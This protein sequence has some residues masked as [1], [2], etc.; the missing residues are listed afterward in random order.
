M[1]F[2][3]VESKLGVLIIAG[4]LGGMVGVVLAVGGDVGAVALGG[5]A[6]LVG[7]VLF[8]ARTF[9]GRG[10]SSSPRPWWRMTSSCTASALLAIFFT[11]QSGWVLM[12]SGATVSSP[13]RL[14]ATVILLFVAVA[15]LHSALRL[16]RVLPDRAAPR[17][18]QSAD[19]GS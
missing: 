14:G 1:R 19:A 13:V 2:R 3:S 4:V 7:V 17:S 12:G 8:A 10:E 9:R 11:I 15:Y 5:S 6:V 16:T 18:A